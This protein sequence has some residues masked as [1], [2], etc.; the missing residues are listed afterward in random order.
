MVES[1]ELESGVGYIKVYGENDLKDQTLTKEQFADAVSAFKASNAPGLIIDIRG[2]TGGADAMSAGFL[3]SFYEKKTLYEYQ[4]WFDSATGKMEIVLE[5]E[6]A[7]ESGGGWARDAGL[8][9]EPAQML[10]EG[11]VV[12]LVNSGCISSGEG[13]AMG[14]KN[15]PNGAVVGFRGTNGSFGMVMGPV[16]TMPGG[17]AIMFPVGQSLDGDKQIQVDSRNGK[18][19]ITP[20]DRVPMTLENAVQSAAG[21]DIELEYALKV[22]QEKK[23]SGE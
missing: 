4:N 20:T 8:Y 14:I 5:D 2:N 22:L 9:I 21:R 10:F 15:L 11:A 17:Y 7:Q 6:S 1:R 16:I 13:V 3:G 18:G 12:A 23:T 19:G